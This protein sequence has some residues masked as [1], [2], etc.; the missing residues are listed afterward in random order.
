MRRAPRARLPFPRRLG[1]VPP[2]EA[3]GAGGATGGSDDDDPR[4]CRGPRR[5]LQAPRQLQRPPREAL[6][7]LPLGGGAGLFPGRPLPRLE[8]HP[9]R[10]HAALRRDR[11]G[12]RACSATRPATPTATPS[13]AR[14]GS[15][16]A[17]TATGASRRT[18]HDGIVTV[19]ADSYEGK[20]LNSPER[21]RRRAPTAAIWFT[22]P[23]YGIDSDY[24]G[25]QA[26]SEIGACHVYRVDPWSGARRGSPP[27]ISCARTGSPSRRTSAGSTSPTPAP[28]TSTTGRATSACFDVAEDGRL[29]GGEVFATC[30]N[31]ALRRLPPRRGRPDLDERRRRRPLLRP[32]RHPDRQGRSCPELV[33]NVVF[34]GPK[35]NRL[36]ICGT[37]S[38]YA[39]T[40]QTNGVKTF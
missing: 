13:T 27:T 20:R 18:E 32:R 39:V 38:L 14:A 16:P 24:E 10:P 29:S 28:A 5:A 30:T 36:F 1:T 35:R 12:G 9:E 33:A 25:H 26:E 34:G 2:T 11:R 17:S 23:A 15:S 3:R 31:G 7:G 22:D 4:F 21:R 40:V 37:T 19:I 6:R 8:R